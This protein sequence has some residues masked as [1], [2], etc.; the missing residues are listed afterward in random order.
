ML[1]RTRITSSTKI[2]ESQQKKMLIIMIII[3]VPMMGVVSDKRQV[4]TMQTRQT[5]GG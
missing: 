2:T 3:A 4:F 1:D 5:V